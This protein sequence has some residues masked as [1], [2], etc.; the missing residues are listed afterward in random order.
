MS[1]EFTNLLSNVNKI[2][3]PCCSIVQQ[4]LEYRLGLPS[5]GERSYK[6]SSLLID[7]SR[8]GV[9]KRSVLTAH[10]ESTEC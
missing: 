2:L 1:T 6:D 10:L 9:D 7:F 3:I 4:N 8:F 5:F